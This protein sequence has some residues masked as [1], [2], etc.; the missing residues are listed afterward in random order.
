VT[1]TFVFEHVFRAP[2]PAVLFELYFDATHAA[3]SDV[4]MGIASR[5]ILELD[6]APDTRRRVSRVVPERQLPAFM[7]PFFPSKLHYLETVIWHKAD[8]RMDLDVRPSLLGGRS[9]V[10]ST[11]RLR[12]EGPG[13]VRR[14]YEGSVS[15][16]VALVGG[17]IERKIIADMER[18]L[19]ISARCTQDYLDRGN[20][21]PLTGVA[22]G[23]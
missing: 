19:A 17:R 8:D 20:T 12:G 21:P 15:V 13:L 22:A 18:T 11:Y 10:L 4:A 16:E 7:R 14:T 2:S 1:A 9:H 5:E 6:D 23:T 3:N